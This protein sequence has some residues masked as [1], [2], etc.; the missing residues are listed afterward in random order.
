MK[1]ATPAKKFFRTVLII[2]LI[3]VLAVLAYAAYVLISYYRIEDNLPLEPVTVADD[4]AAVGQEYTIMSYNIGFCAYT[5]D[6]GFFMDGGRE[7]RARSP[8]TIRYVMDK[9]TSLINYIDPDIAIIEEVDFDSTRSYHMDEYGM[10]NG[11]M[12]KYTHIFAQ[13][14][15]SPYLFYPI[16]CPHGASRSG[17][18]T[19]AR[20]GISSA[21]RRSLPIEESLMKLVDLDRCYSVAR[22]PAGEHELVIFSVHLSA[23]SSDGSIGNEQLKMLCD[24]MQEEYEKGNYVIAGGDFNKDL[25]GKGPELFNVADSD[26]TWARPIP[27]GFFDG[28]DL[29]LV[30]PFDEKRR[31]PSCRNADGPYMPGQYVIT[32]D[33]FIVSDNVTVL[34]SEVIDTGFAFSDHNPVTMNFILN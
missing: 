20:F 26:Y 18:A 34:A 21:V 28:Y 24:N 19:Y 6:Y 30:A 32:P 2:L 11:S 23:Y 7:S 8:E 29:T 9:I 14:Y 13:N 27:E 25:L 12:R 22:I 16:L 5:D 33:G 31:V 1:K 3:L 10:L 15:D 4:E 17:I